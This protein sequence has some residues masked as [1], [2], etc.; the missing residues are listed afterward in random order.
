MVTNQERINNST[1]IGLLED[2]QRGDI[3]IGASVERGIAVQEVMH[4]KLGAA[5]NKCAP[6]LELAG[7]TFVAAP[8][9]CWVITVRQPPLSVQIVLNIY[10]W[11]IQDAH[12]DRFCASNKTD[13]KVSSAVGV[14]EPRGRSRSARG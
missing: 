11:A 1:T 12:L 4:G 5:F 7:R 10:R 3:G 2:A 6:Q 13:V 9:S 14:P 8:S